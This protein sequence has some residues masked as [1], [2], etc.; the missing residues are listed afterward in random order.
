[1]VSYKLY[2]ILYELYSITKYYRIKR[3]PLLKYKVK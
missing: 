2:V 1:M 3:D